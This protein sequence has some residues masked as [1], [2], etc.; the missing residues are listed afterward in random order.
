[1][2]NNFYI[3]LIPLLPLAAF[4]LLGLWGRK[5][6]KNASGIMATALMLVSTILA[7]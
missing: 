4:L 6:F 5:Y 7:I 3:A 1:M 2:P